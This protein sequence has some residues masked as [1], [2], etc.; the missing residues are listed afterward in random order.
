MTEQ[1]NILSENDEVYDDQIHLNDS[2]ETLIR[3]HC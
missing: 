2:K 3:N 1:N